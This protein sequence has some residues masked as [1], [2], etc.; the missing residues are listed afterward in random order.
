[1]TDY[2]TVI[3]DLV[4]WN[5]VRRQAVHERRSISSQVEYAIDEVDEK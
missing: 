2:K 5:K 1:M 3:I 4:H